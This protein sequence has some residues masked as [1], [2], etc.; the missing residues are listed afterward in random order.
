MQ[1]EYILF[2]CHGITS[3]FCHLFTVVWPDAI[4][5]TVRARQWRA[6]FHVFFFNFDGRDYCTGADRFVCVLLIIDVFVV[7]S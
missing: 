2:L 6:C 4:F 5:V 1:V 7:R 3:L